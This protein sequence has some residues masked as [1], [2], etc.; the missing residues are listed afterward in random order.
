[1]T[2]VFGTN[3][4]LIYSMPATGPDI[5]GTA[6]SLIT[7]NTA[8][9]PPYQLPP[10]QNIW[11]PAVLAGRSIMIASSG[12]YDIGAS[13]QNTLILT[14]DGTAGT[15]GLYTIAS[16]GAA[17]WPATTTGSW[18]SQVWMSCVSTGTASTWYTGGQLT[19]GPG[20]APTATAS[21]YMWGGAVTAG[22]PQPLTVPTNTALFPEMYCTW[23][24]APT[25]F[26]CTQFM[27]FGLN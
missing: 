12:G 15:S 2:F 20:N 9:N 11:S 24:A 16:T 22:I 8:T 26:V 19:V 13:T 5:T 21:T 23:A 6:K 18:E 1:V 27:I 7:G 25:A 3:A 14:L 10:F 4:E 17:T